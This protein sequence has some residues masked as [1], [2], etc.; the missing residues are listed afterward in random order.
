M[1]K[2]EL[3]KR[4][5]NNKR[6]SVLIVALVAASTATTVRAEVS[7]R[8]DSTGHVVVPTFVN[9][10]GPFDFIFDTGAD[11]T[12]VFSWVVERLR[13]PAAGKGEISGATGN[14]ETVLSQLDALSVDRH[15]ILHVRA[16]TL[17]NRADGAH[18][19]G[20]V[21][22]E[23]LAGRLAVADFRC[24]TLALLPLNATEGVVGSHPQWVEA[25]SIADGKQLTLP[26]T[27]NG[28]QGVALLDSGNRATIIN[29]SFAAAAGIDPKSGAFHDGEPARGATRQSVSSRVGPVGTVRFAGI[30]L[31]G[32][33]ARVADLP[34]FESAGLGGEPAMILGLDYLKGTRLYLDF[35]GRRFWIESSKCS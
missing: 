33:V 4:T 24:R 22:V 32:A 2:V 11:D 16:L 9:G 31:D 27:V 25:G 3:C 1:H 12:A 19:A 29:S 23:L 18:L 14:S 5:R 6:W 30:T 34:V 26:V 35:S 8:W 21:G 17:P 15:Q 7:L 13:L 20:I 10:V 28:I